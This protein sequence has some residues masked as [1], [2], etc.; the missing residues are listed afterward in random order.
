MKAL[1]TG[2]NGFTGSHL[3][4][5]LVA[6]G[7]DVVGLVRRTSDLSRLADL[8]VQLVYG[9]ITNAD[10]LNQAMADVDVVFHIA[11]CVD[12]GIVDAARM[13]RVNVEGTRTV[14]TAIRAQPNPPKLVYCSTIG[15]YGDTAGK[16]IDETYQRTQEGFSSAY[17]ETKFKAQ[18][19]VNQHVADG[20]SAVS[21]MSGGI[22]GA[23]D[24]HFGPVIKLFLQGRLPI[25][26]GCDRITGIVHVDDLV[27]AM[28]LAAE[29]APSGEH[30]IISAG[31]LSIG[32][33]F[34]ILGDAAGVKAPVDAP[35]SLV[36]LIGG[37]LDPIGKAFSWN[38]P[39]NNELVHYIYDRCVRI[40][41]EKARRDL[42]WQPRSIPEILTG[43]VKELRV[44]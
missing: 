38:A 15:I 11:A 17:D 44:S 36:R 20:F 18:Q 10:A 37:L 19:L 9:D 41:G 6:Q 24:P 1:V 3:V 43:I 25:W 22:F 33:M 31:E 39:L 13:E 4:Q 30:F 23:D 5:L 21:L 8:D 35:K 2:A 16:V 7:N 26:P 32:E 42:G 28:L 34:N 27:Q 14:L 29:K 40:S 12:L